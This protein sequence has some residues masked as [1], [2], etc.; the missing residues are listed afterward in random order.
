M[1]CCGERRRSLFQ[2]TKRPA[3]APAPVPVVSAQVPF[4]RQP[5]AQQSQRQAQQPQRGAHP[6]TQTQSAVAP[7]LLRYAGSA[8]VVFAGPVT[9][10]PYAF[11]GRGSM[12]SV[13][14]RDAVQML[15][16]SEFERG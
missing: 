9:G 2:P 11:S 10:K 16:L 15:R 3:A 13:D 5:F 4:G 14:A 12:Q 8:R 1:A 6:Q 7:M